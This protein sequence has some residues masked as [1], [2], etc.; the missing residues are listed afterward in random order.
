MPKKLIQILFLLLVLACDKVENPLPTVY[1]DF[2]WELYPNDP[3]TYPYDI[4]NPSNNWTLNTNE[5][6][7]LLE[8]Y[9]GHKCTNCPAAA[10]IATQLE[11]DTALGVI[12]V[13]IHA[14]TD[15]SF[16]STDEVEFT[17]DY[18]TDAGDA[19]VQEM[20]GFIGNPMGTINR[21]DGGYSNTNW[22]F[23]SN[24]ATGV[25]NEISQGNLDANVQLQYNYYPSTNG[26]FIHTETTFLNTLS[27]NY[28]LI[29][30]LIRNDVVSPQK[31][32]DGTIDHH[33]HHHAVLSNNINGTWGTLV[34]D[35]AVVNGDVF[36]HDFSFELPDSSTDSTYEVNNLSLVTYIC[37]RNNFNILQAIKTEL[38]S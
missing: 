38:G 35:S 13:S 10:T 12:V 15:G 19:Y 26:L 20:P 30:Y 7:I 1:G 31:M 34:N 23:S 37:E 29:V 9:T 33:Y 16:Q 25:N 6:G 22:Y 14:S 36:Y 11:D 8:D 17:V 2:N 28:H 32:N 27:G 21:N 3:T 4:A 5:K 24:W 18:Q